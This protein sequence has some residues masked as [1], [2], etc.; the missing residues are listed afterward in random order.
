MTRKEAPPD[1]GTPQPAAADGGG[2]TRNWR[3][4]NPEKSGGAK[5]RSCGADLTAG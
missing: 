1:R 3:W 5:S 2:V 4:A